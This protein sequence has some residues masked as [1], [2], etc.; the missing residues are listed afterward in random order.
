MKRLFALSLTLTVLSCNPQAVQQVADNLKASPSPAA[1]VSVSPTP[2]ASA[3]ISPNRV[4]TEAQVKKD[5]MVPDEDDTI[6]IALEN[7]DVTSE[8]DDTGTIGKDIIPISYSKDINETIKWE[9]TKDGTYAELRDK[10][11]KVIYKIEQ[12]GPEVTTDITKGEYTFELTSNAITVKD[13]TKSEPV[14]IREEKNLSISGNFWHLIKAIA[15]D[16]PGCCL[17]SAYYPRAL[18]GKRDFSKADLWHANLSGASLSGS[19]FSGAYLE[20]ANLSGAD[21]SYAKFTGANLTGANLM[22]AFLI[23]TSF[24]DT[25]LTNVNFV[26]ADIR[27]GTDFSNA[28]WTDGKKKCAEGSIGECK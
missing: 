6:V 28:I 27:S 25:N 22:R 19:N 21:L 18:F 20:G 16:C 5:K 26:E 7:K 14:F 23:N 3:T 13:G 2:Q 24:R 8:E 11:G 1:T 12:G 15:T 10:D 9:G 4:I 17:S